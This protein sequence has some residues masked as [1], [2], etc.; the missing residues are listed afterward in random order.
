[1]NFRF[2]NWLTEVLYEFKNKDY[3]ELNFEIVEEQDFLKLTQ[4]EP[5][6]IYIVI[7]EL[8]DNKMFQKVNIQPIQILIL[9]EEN[10]QIMTQTIFNTIATNYNM[11]AYF[12]NG[13]FVKFIFTNPVV[14]SNFNEIS[15]GYRS[16]LYMTCQLYMMDNI[17]DVTEIEV[18][19]ERI[20]VLNFNMNYVMTTSTN[21]FPVAPNPEYIARSVKTISC[22]NIGFTAI[23]ENNELLASLLDIVDEHSDGEETFFLS[24]KIGSKKITKK[25]KLNQLT[26]ASAPNDVPSWQIGFIK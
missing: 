15:S 7:K 26:M 19:S 11:K 21:Q 13:E 16:V 17:P 10:S 3:K 4:Y 2:K 9:C 8:S 18:N 24:F 25:M 22:L 5:S 6:K 12:E 1:M 20:N 14:A 23:L